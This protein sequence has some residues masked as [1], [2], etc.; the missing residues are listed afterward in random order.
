MSL[1]SL[2]IKNFR[3]LKEVDITLSAG[4]NL[5]QGVN[6]SGKTSLLE[7]IHFLGRARSFRT[8]QIS[9]LV[10]YGE[11]FLWV[12]GQVRAGEGG[13]RRV[14]VTRHY[15]ETRVEV[16]GQAVRTL[17]ELAR[18]LPVQVV[19]AESHQLIVGGPRYRRRF[20]DWGVFHVEP[21]FHT[22][23]QHFARSLKQR[24]AVLRMRATGTAIQA[25]DTTLDSAAQGIEAA[26]QRYIERLSARLP[27][28]V[29]ETLGVSDLE[30]RY[31]RGWPAE[32]SYREVLRNSIDEDR[33]V[34]YTRYGP[35]RSD[36]MLYVGNVAAEN[37]LSRG[38]QKLLVF[39]LVL[40]Q[41][42]M[43]NEATGR[44][45]LLLVDDVFS[46]L[47]KENCDRVLRA[48]SLTRAQTFVTTVNP[49]SVS[50]VSVETWDAWSVF[51]VEHGRVYKV[52]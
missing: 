43:F 25:W 30:L 23:W 12:G 8:P 1:I 18:W 16:A 22:H 27:H 39:A 9:P 10:T 15:D 45:G 7:A 48:L 31:A 49:D 13:G 36:L 6:A 5:V 38:Q 52:V 37:R 32:R 3:I 46:E 14:S 19:D 34:G 4:L 47:D 29:M 24:N 42:Q 50:S 11:T 41:A 21:S 33:A 51:H 20:M 40:T 44:K 2:G 35:H 28:Y 26:R 17:S